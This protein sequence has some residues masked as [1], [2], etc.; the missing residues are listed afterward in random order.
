MSKRVFAA[1]IAAAGLIGSVAVAEPAAAPAAAAA[2]VARAPSPVSW[3][4]DPSAPDISGVWVRTDSGAAS[5][6]SKEGWLPWPPPLKPAFASVW[7]KR[8]ADATAGTRTD[9]PVR[10]CLPPGMP[11]FITGTNG[12]LQIIQTPGRATL[13]RD[14]VPVRRIWTDGRS[15]PA[16]KDVEEFSN[17]NAV[18]RYVGAELVTDVIGVKDYPIDST[19]VP[20]S[21]SLRIVER[22]RRIDAKTLRVTVTLTDPLA[23]TRPMTSVVTYAALDD[24]RWEPREFICTPSTNYHPEK[25][26]R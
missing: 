26:V 9:D 19:G 3:Y 1:A 18:G 14:G 13:Y 4:G 6:T 16:A 2:P 5:A 7:K 23:F 25:Y 15:Q 11:R 22:Y 21:P 17:G 12:P 8:L 24:P 20:H 10:A